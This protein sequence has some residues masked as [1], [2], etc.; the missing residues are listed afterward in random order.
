MFWNGSAPT[1]GPGRLLSCLF[2]AGADITPAPSLNQ[3]VR[4]KGPGA[5]PA[6]SSRSAK[7]GT[8]IALYTIMKAFAEVPAGRW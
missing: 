1:P 8:D 6:V 7:V 2:I 5:D 4:R 3:T